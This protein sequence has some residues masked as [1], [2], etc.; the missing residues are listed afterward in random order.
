MDSTLNIGAIGFGGSAVAVNVT[1]A[2][3]VQWLVAAG[4]GIYLLF[5]QYNYCRFLL[6]LY[7]VYFL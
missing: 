5:S 4:V 7:T 3:V 6:Q 2:Q 1:G